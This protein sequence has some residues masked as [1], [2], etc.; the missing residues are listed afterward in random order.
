MDATCSREPGSNFNNRHRA[1]PHL[2]IPTI[3]KNIEW[4][5]EI[6]ELDVTWR[7]PLSTYLVL[8]FDGVGA[9]ICYWLVSNVPRP[10]VNNIVFMR[11]H[12]MRIPG[13]AREKIKYLG[14]LTS[15]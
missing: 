15:V 6:V 9:P 8:A 3:T 4:R 14:A 11:K 12:R 10:D 5:L 13:T 2:T 7:F 1:F